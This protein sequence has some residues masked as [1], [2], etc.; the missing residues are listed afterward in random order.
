MPGRRSPSSVAGVSLDEVAEHLA[1]EHARVTERLAMLDADMAALV[2]ASQDSNA[3][4]EHDPEGPTIAFERSQLAALTRQA[5]VHQAETVAA[6]ERLAAGAY[7]RCER[8]GLPLDTARLEA[9]PH[10]RTCVACAMGLA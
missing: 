8:C 10:A 2:A 3:D 7:G 5:R 4:D 6:Q 9:R 1:R